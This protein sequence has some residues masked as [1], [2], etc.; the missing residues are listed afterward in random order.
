MILK[1]LIPVKLS[2][3]ILPKQWLIEKYNLIEVQFFNISYCFFIVKLLMPKEDF[4]SLK[5]WCVLSPLVG[6][7]LYFRYDHGNWALGHNG[8]SNL[9]HFHAHELQLYY[10]TFII[11]KIANSH[12]GKKTIH[13][14]ENLLS[15]ESSMK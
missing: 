13:L 2:I 7:T 3:G 11:V 15:F 8:S 12:Y 5:V 4:K 1:Y 9:K 6:S 14:S 10:M